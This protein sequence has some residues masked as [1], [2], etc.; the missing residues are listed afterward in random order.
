MH[1]LAVDD[2]ARRQSVPGGGVQADPGDRSEVFGQRANQT[3]QFGGDVTGARPPRAVEY[4][5]ALLCRLQPQEG[6][7]GADGFVYAV[8]EASHG[9]WR[10]G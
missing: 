9:G 10:I 2:Q 7:T 3:W 5:R 8:R 6:R 4:P 1:D